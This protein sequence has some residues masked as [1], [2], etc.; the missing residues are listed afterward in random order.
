MARTKMIV[1]RRGDEGLVTLVLPSS[2]WL[3]AWAIRASVD[4]GIH[5]I[6]AS[7]ITT[8][9]SLNDC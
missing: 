5:V 4:L 2:D 6:I 7:E 9:K 3:K 1:G 8:L